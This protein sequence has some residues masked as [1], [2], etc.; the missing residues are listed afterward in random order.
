ME[1]SG[2]GSEGR[3]ESF[4]RDIMDPP[5]IPPGRGDESQE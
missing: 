3:A 2:R 5:V 4:E 1:W